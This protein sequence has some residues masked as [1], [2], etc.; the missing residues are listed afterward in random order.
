MKKKKPKIAVITL[1]LAALL[2]HGGVAAA[3]S[4]PEELP[5]QVQLPNVD[6]IF[7]YGILRD[8]GVLCGKLESKSKAW[9]AFGAHSEGK[10]QMI[11]AHAVIALPNEKT[12]QQY[13]LNSKSNSGIKLLSEGAQT[14]TEAS[15]TQEGGGTVARFK[16]PLDF[17]GLKLTSKNVYM[18]AMGTSNELG[19]HGHKNRGFVTLDFEKN[20]SIASTSDESEQDQNLR[21]QAIYSTLE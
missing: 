6:L 20:I 19:Y 4:C 11:G 13:M 12:V 16:Q 9:V 8:E 18:L 15:V 21:G 3:K 5:G 17:N 1:C 2:S 14:L 10:K 7:H